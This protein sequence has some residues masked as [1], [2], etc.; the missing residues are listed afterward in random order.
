MK[1]LFKAICV[2]LAIQA[3]PASAADFGIIDQSTI[4][5]NDKFTIGMFTGVLH[6]TSKELVY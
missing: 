1:T 4:A 3:V 6:T 5:D 2:A